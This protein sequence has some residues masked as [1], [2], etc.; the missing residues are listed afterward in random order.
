MD[1]T[2]F[3]PIRQSENLRGIKRGDYQKDGLWYCGNCHTPK[4]HRFEYAG[5][6]H[7]VWCLCKC[8]SAAEEERKKQEAYR[9]EMRRIENLKRASM[10][11][12]TFR[13]VSFDGYQVRKENQKA[14]RVA[15]RYVECFGEMEKKNQGLLFFGPVGTG[16]SHTSACIA[17]ELMGRGISVIMTSFVKILQD[18]TGKDEGQYIDT[19]NTARLLII[20]D[21]GAER[22]TDYAMEKVYNII[23][24]RVRANKPM[25]LTTNL[26]VGEMMQCDDVRYKRIYDRIFEVCY[27]VEV[28]GISFRLRQ[29]AERQ[30]AMKKLFE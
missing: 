27:P 25:I 11:P 16:K 12:G 28:N 26:K 17:N 4:Q 3:L 8:E 5:I 19:L 21:L 10:M 29:A 1:M 9:E 22:N 6:S 20:D 24:S 15:L 2:E 7:T 18:I 14:Y 13:N 30:E 23:D